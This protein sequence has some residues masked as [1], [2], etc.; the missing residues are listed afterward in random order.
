M[1]RAIIVKEIHFHD[2]DHN[3]VSFDKGELIALDPERMIGYGHGI[4]FDV[5]KS[6]VAIVQ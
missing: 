6:E 1:L 5:N 3:L 2:L 4:H